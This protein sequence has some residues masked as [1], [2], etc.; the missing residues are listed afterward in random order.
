MEQ[1]E[2]KIIQKESIKLSVSTKGVYTWEIKVFLNG[3]DIKDQDRLYNIDKS[4]KEK[5]GTPGATE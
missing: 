3:D 5:Y 1:E 2:Q 4:L